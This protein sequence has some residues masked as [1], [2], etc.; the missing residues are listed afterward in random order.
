MASL[1]TA[2]ARPAKAVLRSDPPFF[3]HVIARELR[4]INLR[5]VVAPL[6]HESLEL[7]LDRLR[8][9][10]EISN[11]V[12][13][14]GERN[15]FSVGQGDFGSGGALFVKPNAHVRTIAHDIDL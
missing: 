3:F 10:G 14:G 6:Y 15:A 12:V 9:G 2:L 13:E 1:V 11:D 4:G 5:D 8:R 7:L